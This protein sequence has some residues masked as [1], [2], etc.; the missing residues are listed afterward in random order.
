MSEYNT[1]GHEKFK[2]RYH[3]IFSTRWRR[4]CLEEMHDD[5]L[6]SFKRAESLQNRWTIAVVETDKDHV[7]FLIESTPIV[8]PIEIVHKLK[9][10][11]TYDMWKGHHDYLR[12]F[13]WKG[14]HHLWTR[15]YFCSTIGDVSEK[16]LKAYIENQG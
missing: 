11:S 6:I 3:I 5:L 7:H 12:K 1:L 4:K 10:I 13:F 15:G 8:S 9:Q 16:T 14:P 2:I